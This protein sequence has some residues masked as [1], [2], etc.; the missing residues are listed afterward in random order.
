MPGHEIVGRVTRVGKEVSCFKVGDLADTGCLVDSC[1]TCP[2]CRDGLEQ[3][4][5]NGFVFTYN[6]PDKHSAGWGTWS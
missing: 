1:R 5:A 3:F 4:C 2:S 6:G